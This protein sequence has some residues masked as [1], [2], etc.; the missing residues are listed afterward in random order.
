MIRLVALIAVLCGIAGTAFAG[1]DGK[2]TGVKA[3]APLTYSPFD[4]FNARQTLV[5]TVQNTGTLN[6]SYRVSVPPSFYPLQF[7]G[8]LS[9]SLSTTIAS[10]DTAGTLTLTTPILGPG[11]SA[12]SPIILTA[13]RGQATSSGQF[14]AGFG[15]ALAA[16]GAPV[17]SPPID[18]VSVPLTCTVPPVFEINLAGSGHRTSVQFGNLETGKNA[19]VM[20]QTRTNG[21]HRLE[22][23]SSNRGLLA[24]R[25]HS[26]PAAT[27]PYTA[28]VD[29]QPLALASPAALS[30]A[31][32]P[33]EATRRF[34]VTIGNTS[35]KLA[36]TY[37]DVITVAILSSM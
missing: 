31:T 27:I 9:F 22:F 36:G 35:G 12:Q 16:V 13:L 23:E 37:R 19:S 30:F 33:G 18:Q 26:G 8:K 2:I 1:C 34:T 3:Q 7:G 10:G 4:A 24:L 11:N 32:A 20:L 14:I 17:G 25:G 21:N 6:C 28:T 15:L 29:G 5:V